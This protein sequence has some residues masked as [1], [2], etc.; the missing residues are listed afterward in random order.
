MMDSNVNKNEGLERESMQRFLTN[1]NLLDLLLYYRVNC[2]IIYVL[3]IDIF[4]FIFVF[5]SANQSLDQGN[6]KE[7]VVKVYI[8]S[9]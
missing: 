4:A 9:S 8:T 2:L 5:I 3:K 7:K 1:F 6:P